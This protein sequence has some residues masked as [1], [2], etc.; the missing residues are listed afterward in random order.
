V[1]HAVMM[2]AGWAGLQIRIA[3]LWSAPHDLRIYMPHL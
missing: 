1:L 2:R 3:S